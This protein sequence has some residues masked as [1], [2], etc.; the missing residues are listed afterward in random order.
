M[1]LASAESGDTLMTVSANN[2]SEIIILF[3]KRE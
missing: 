1:I 3:S 2:D